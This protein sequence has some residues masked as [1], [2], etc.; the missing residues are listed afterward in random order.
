[1]SRDITVAPPLERLV[2][3]F[4]QL[5]IDGLVAMNEL[6]AVFRAHQT[7]LDRR[8][9]LK[10][11]PEFIAEDEKLVDAFIADARTMAPLQHPN[12]VRVFDFG[13]SDG[14]LWVIQEWVEGRTLREVLA[15]EAIGTRRSGELLARLCQ[16]LAY[17][18]EH[19]VIHGD[20]RASHIMIDDE[21]QVKLMNFGLGRI[22]LAN[23]DVNMP[24]VVA[25]ELLDPDLEVDH[26]ADIFALGVLLYE[27]LV[28]GRPVGEVEMPSVARPGIVGP[29]FDMIV[30]GCL[31]PDP[32]RRFQN[33]TAL[34]MALEEL[35]KI[36]APS[37]TPRPAVKAVPR[38]TGASPP[39]RR[40]PVYFPDGQPVRPEM[41]ADPRPAAGGCDRGLVLQAPP[42]EH[43]GD[44]GDA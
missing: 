12:L 7:R 11:L 23:T 27:M 13:E 34:R 26:R 39:P 37:I 4:P 21:E 5:E 6:S 2:P 15:E 20:I 43:R 35:I 29:E 40:Q 14:L 44:R 31:H 16:G 22:V 42:R 28:G 17:A 38:L 1:M 24:G 8:V 41:A 10:I 32:E 30:V 9:A 36:P 19:G 3:L 18:H 25:P 33:C